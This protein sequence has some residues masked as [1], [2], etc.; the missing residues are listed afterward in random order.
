MRPGRAA[1][2]QRPGLAG[3]GAGTPLRSMRAASTGTT[4]KPTSSEQAWQKTT[5]RASD[6]NSAPLVDCMNTSGR[7][8]TQVVRVEATMAPPTSAAPTAAA[9][10]GAAPPSSRLRTMLSSTTMALSTIMP[11]PSASPPK[12]IWLRVRPAEVE[13]ARSRR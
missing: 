10:S 3:R 5:T 6:W 12:V 8:T 1:A 13:Q 11:T 4:V 9:S 2:W 7:N